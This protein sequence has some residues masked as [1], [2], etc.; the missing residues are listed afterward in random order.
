MNV[1]TSTM[2]APYRAAYAEESAEVE[3]LFANMEKLKGLTKKIQGSL[4]RLEASG[5]SM[6][7]AINPIYSNT[8]KLQTTN[9]N[10]DRILEAID[11]IREPLDQSSQEEHIIR[12]DPRQIGI[13]EYIA[14]LD[15]TTRA[16]KGLKRSNLK[17]NQTAVKELNQQLQYGMKQLEYIF[18]ETL[19]EDARPIEPLHFITKGAQRFYKCQF[20]GKEC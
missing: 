5:K 18:R 14:S 16:L 20:L 15:R 19:Q 4:N 1:A 7:D 11:R 6:Q 9:R 8:K 12:S 10:V 3:V 13:R 2:A 17:M